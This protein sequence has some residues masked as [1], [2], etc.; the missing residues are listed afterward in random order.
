MNKNKYEFKDNYVVG[1]TKK[2]EPFYFDL[3]DFEYVYKYVWHIEKR[4]YCKSCNVYLHRLIYSKY[5]EID[6][7]IID[8]INRNKND[9]R[10][11]NLRFVSSC[12]NVINRGV[13]KSNKSGFT[14]VSFN[15]YNAKGEKV[16]R[17]YIRINGQQIDLG[18]FKNKD[19]AIISRLKAESEYFGDFAP[20]KSL[21]K[22]YNINT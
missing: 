15:N 7:K 20:Q 19:E 1:Y 8:H 3:E 17:A 4:G 11:T 10:K 6:G 2:Q 18:L 9:N 16:W 14:G 5:Y 12:E 21:F 22:K 13:L